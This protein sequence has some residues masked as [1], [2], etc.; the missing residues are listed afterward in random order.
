MLSP[1][2]RNFVTAASLDSK[3][4]VLVVGKSFGFITTKA[5]RIEA[6]LKTMLKLSF[7]NIAQAKT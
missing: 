2:R 7:V 6:V 5:K 1:N 3:T 4:L